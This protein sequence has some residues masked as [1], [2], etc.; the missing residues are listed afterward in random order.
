MR[1]LVLGASGLLGSRVVER[2]LNR[3]YFTAGTYR[4]SRPNFEI[5][6]YP[7]NIRDQEA[8]IRTVDDVD[9][10]TIINCAAMTDV[11][12]CEKYPESAFDI[13]ANAPGKLATYAGQQNI[14]F[15]QVSTDYVFSGNQDKRYS[16]ASEPSPVQVYGESKIKG[17]QAVRNSP[18]ESMILRLSFL[19]GRRGDT[20]KIEGFPA[21]AIDQFSCKNS[22][23]LI[24]DQYVTPTR[25]GNAADA[26]FE[27]IE[28]DASFPDVLH[29]ACRSCITPYEFGSM[30][31]DK[32]NFDSVKIEEQSFQ[33]IERAAERP[34]NTCLD[35]SR[36]RS[37]LSRN[38]PELSE[39]IDTLI[40]EHK[41]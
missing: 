32:L 11:D 9:P 8:V 17:E 22:V 30:I 39:D 31:V 13:N 27:V 20:G 23:Q 40:E 25:A 37:L 18:A 14:R 16:E 35:T 33:D 4:T 24:S 15:V 5:S 28:R 7:L 36:Y 10:D 3:E 1:I 2:A 41:F 21:W 29:V 19:Y 34:I 38:V 12:R 26:I 6:L